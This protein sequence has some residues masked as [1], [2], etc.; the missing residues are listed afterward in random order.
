MQ[1][2]VVCWN[3]TDVSEEHFVSIFTA[4]KPNMKQATRLIMET[5]IYLRNVG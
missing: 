1:R 2:H 3:S 5:N 4:E